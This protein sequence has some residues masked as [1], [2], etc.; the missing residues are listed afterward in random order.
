MEPL[1][2]LLA[3]TA[4]VWALGRNRVPFATALRAGVAAMF[5]LTGAAHFIGLREEL[6]SMVPP[7]LPAP[8]LLVTATGVLELGGAVALFV[9]RLAAWAAGGLALLLIA[10][11]PANVYAAQAGIV[12][13]WWSQ[14]WPRTVLQLV[15]LAAVTTVFVDRWRA[16][17]GVTTSARRRSL[18]A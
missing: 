10:M 18:Q 8:E 9:P 7:A 1:L 16:R 4:A 6:I 11:F 13:D 5:L 3:V 15:F 12:D 17:S 2:A 14:L